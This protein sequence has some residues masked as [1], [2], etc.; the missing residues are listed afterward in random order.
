[1]FQLLYKIELVCLSHLAVTH[2][3][4]LRGW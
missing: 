3:T 2:M 4:G 1:M